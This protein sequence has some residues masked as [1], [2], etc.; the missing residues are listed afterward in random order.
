M[1]TPFLATA[2]DTARELQ[3]LFNELYIRVAN[4]EEW[5]SET[6]GPLLDHDAFFAA[7]WNIHIEVKKAGAVQPVV[8]GIFRSDYMLHIVPRYRGLKQVE[9]NTFSVAGACHAECVARMHQHLRRVRSMEE[10]GR[11]CHLS[12]TF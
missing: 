11:C 2:F 7:L 12:L 10:V 4:D 6:L 1:P 5:L 3:P 9:M 8:C